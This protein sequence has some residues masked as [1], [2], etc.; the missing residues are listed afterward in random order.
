MAVERAGMTAEDLRVYAHM[1]NVET[2]IET[3]GWKKS[4]VVRD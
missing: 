2:R 3:A 1:D 4:V